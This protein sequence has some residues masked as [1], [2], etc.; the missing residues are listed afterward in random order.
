MQYPKENIRN[1]ILII[2]RK[3]FLIHGYKGTSMRTIAKNTEVS[4]SNIYNYF[5]NKDEIFREVLTPVITDLDKIIDSHNNEDNLDIKIFESREYLKKHTMIFVELIL[6]YREELKIL[7]LNS[8][9]SELEGFTEEYIEKNTKKGLEYLQ[10]MKA[11]YPWL[12]IN[13]SDFFI[14]TMSSW[15]VSTIS[16]LIMHDLTR[17]ELEIFLNEYMSYS[18][19]GWK[20]IMRVKD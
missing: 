5:K 4:L 6:Q 12:N 1:R 13:V 7:F 2:A 16:E 9:G 15:W 3:E 20:N 18:T 17:D 11:R 19:G 14:H 10:L 8:H